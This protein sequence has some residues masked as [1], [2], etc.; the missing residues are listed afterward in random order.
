VNG[1]S[2][3]SALTD[4]PT[5]IMG[6]LLGAA[7]LPKLKRAL[8]IGLGTGS[9]AGWLASL[10][11]IERV[12]VAE[13]EP[14][15]SHVARRCAAV[16]RDALNNPK[17]RILRGDARELLGVLHG[18]YDVIFSEPSNPYRAGVAS[19]YAREFYAAVQ[20]RLA[21][22]GLFIQWLQAYDVDA[23]GIRTIYATLASAFPHVETWNGLRED[24]F[25]VAS[26]KSLVHDVAAL[27]ARIA[28]QPFASALRLAWYADGLEGFLAHYVANDDFTHVMAA[29]DAP[30][31]TDDISP[32]EFGFARTARGGAH[33]SLSSLL[34]AAGSREA[35]RPQLRGGS[36]D[37]QRVDYEAEAF[38]LLNGSYTST[39]T[40]TPIYRN[41]F[42]MLTKWMN[43]D[44]PGALELWNLIGMQ[45]G[46][47][48]PSA[49]ERLARAEMLAY[50]GSI[51]S[52]REI[53]RLLRDRPT[54][55]T[56]MRAV[57]LLLHGQRKAGSELV[58]STLQRY[59]GDPWPHPLPMLRML[60]TLQVRD[61]SDSVLLP[62]WL[63]ALA[64]PFAL[65]V[66][67]AARDRT[68][69][70]LAFALEREH[71]AVP[72]GLL[73]RARQPAPRASRARLATVS[74]PGSGRARAA[75]AT[76]SQSAIVTPSFRR[77]QPRRMRM[78]AQIPSKKNPT[79]QVPKPTITS[80][81]GAE[82]SAIRPDHNT[83]SQ[84]VRIC[85]R[86]CGSSQV[87]R[88]S[89]RSA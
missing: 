57:Y 26:R 18:D 60:S 63:E 49:I 76:L 21:P 19:L 89:P 48:Q 82:T 31:N 30:I 25:L 11:E 77:S 3:G 20:R 38:A 8:V 80:A 45:S 54:E 74:P 64:H 67:E 79:A 44:F 88:A 33:F 24:L 62:G 52:E 2:D 7:L 71:V 56:A 78:L 13:I 22:N 69:L 4:A 16:N 51:E 35:E 87:P 5:Q 61:T 83:A 12:D 1:K 17:L 43:A 28:E 73:R 29:G 6:G 32:V 75:A 10:P 72:R 59:R 84:K 9:T 42:A 14:A 46:E 68:R 55:A 36:V 85:Q 53:G 37:F 58:L 70:R 34:A 41:R 15:I 50:N 47:I 23:R 81:S 66:N 27:R 86:K 39:D 40:L 65:R